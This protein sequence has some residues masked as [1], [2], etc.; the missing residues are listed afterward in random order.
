MPSLWR[1]F[2]KAQNP[3]EKFFFRLQFKTCWI[4]RGFEQLSSSIGWWF[5]A[6]CKLFKN[7]KKN[8][9]RGTL[10]ARYLIVGR[11]AVGGGGAWV[12]AHSGI[13]N[14]IFSNELLSR[15]MFCSYFREF[16]FHH[17]FAHFSTP[18]KIFLAITATWKNW[19]ALRPV[20]CFHI[21]TRLRLC[22]RRVDTTNGRSRNLE[23]V[24]F[25][26]CVAPVG[27]AEP[28]ERWKA[29]NC[30]PISNAC[31]RA[32]LLIHQTGVVRGMKVMWRRH[33]FSDKVFA[34]ELRGWVFD[35]RPLS[36]S[37]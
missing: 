7:R 26:L 12:L 22:L 27:I 23:F 34:S 29:T 16:S 4:H 37:P 17:H 9:A 33:S 8:G 2:Q 32:V 36:E 5:M 13:W 14:L 24:A 21:I 15:K 20:A 6:L 10:K 31:T 1:H 30:R 19:E 11:M 28:Y 3:K 25:M 18:R 35:P